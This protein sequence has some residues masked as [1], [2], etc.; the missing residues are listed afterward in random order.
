[1]NVP[2]SMGVV[3]LA[4]AT[5]AQAPPQFVLQAPAAITQNF[6][7]ISPADVDGDG[8]LDLF[9][10]RSSFPVTLVTLLRNDGAFGFTDVS[11]T[12]LPAGQQ[13]QVV[14]P[15]DCDGDGDLDAFC[16]GIPSTQTG[17]LLRN[18][19]SGT[20]I[21]AATFPNLAPGGCVAADLDNDGDLDLALAA[22]PLLGGL[23]RVLVNNGV[24]GF[25]GGPSFPTASGSVGVSD[26][27]G[28]GDLDLLYPSPRRLLRNNGGLS[29]TDIGAT[30]LVLPTPV[31]LGNVACGD[32][33]GD[34]DLD[35]VLQAVGGDVLVFDQGSTLVQGGFAP[36]QPYS[37]YLELADCDR[38]GDLDLLRSHPTGTISFARNDGFGTFVDDPSRLPLVP[39]FSTA[40]HAAD[41][42]RDGDPEVLT[43]YTGSQ[44]LLLRNRHVHLELGAALRGQNWSVELW[45]E[46]GYAAADGLGVLAVS[47]VRLAAPLPLPPFGDLWLDL[48]G[49]LLVADSIPQS[50]GRRAF[51]F[52]IPAAPQL[53]GVGLNVQGF[54]GA[55]SGGLHLTALGI[56]TIQ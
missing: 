8:D 19:G 33:D 23:D 28:D 25:S 50:A 5:A 44:A 13:G 40:V 36:P 45:S 6:V 27:D 9:A 42:D 47:L 10:S 29:F 26:F 31:G 53:V 11:A 4:A 16:S 30:H 7:R 38:D 12:R 18:L 15:F 14:T 39:I 37:T 46:P 17:T 56:A 34:G 24:G 21:V 3:L 35:F 52:A 54:V 20:F 51:A 55:G 41:L 49:A 2:L 22:N 1:M 32:L 48:N 43:C